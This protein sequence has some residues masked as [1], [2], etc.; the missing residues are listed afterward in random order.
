MINITKSEYVIIDVRQTG[1]TSQTYSLVNQYST[2]EINVNWTFI[3]KLSLTQYLKIEQWIYDKYNKT[4][5]RVE[6]CESNSHH[7]PDFPSTSPSVSKKS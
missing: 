2:Q 3:Q 7:S 1:V 5:I 4:R 6:K